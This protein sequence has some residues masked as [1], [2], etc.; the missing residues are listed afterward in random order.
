MADG[1]ETLYFLSV[2]SVSFVVRYA[3]H[4]VPLLWF[5]CLRCLIPISLTAVLLVYA[6]LPPNLLFVF[7][8]AN[9]LEKY[10]CSI[11]FPASY[12]LWRK[13]LTQ[14]VLSFNRRLN[15]S[16][17]TMVTWLQLPPTVVT[18]LRHSICEGDRGT[19]KSPGDIPVDMLLH[20]QKDYTSSSCVPLYD[21]PLLLRVFMTSSK[22]GIRFGHL[23]H[24]VILSKY[25]VLSQKQYTK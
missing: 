7:K 6:T 15:P 5:L 21:V 9:Y 13:Q 22:H 18:M 16:A 23:Y 25:L 20:T 2:S 10:L 3:V 14:L 24:S 1:I 12:F 11:T 19:S 17:L 4:A 8:Y